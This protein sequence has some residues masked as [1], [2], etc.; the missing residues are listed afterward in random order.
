MKITYNNYKNF[1][2]MYEPKAYCLMAH[3]ISTFN[4]L[5]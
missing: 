2:A 3:E 5:K 1:Y 4:N